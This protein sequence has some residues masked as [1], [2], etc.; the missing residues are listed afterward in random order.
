MKKIAVILLG[1]LLVSLA[2]G[3][4][5]LSY[6][7]T[8]TEIDRGAVKYAV[9]CGVADANEFKGLPNLAKAVKLESAVDD[10]HAK[11]QQEIQHMAERD[12]LEY[13]IH[14]GKAATN[15]K[16]GKEREEIL[17]GPK[18][19]IPIA[20][21]GLGFA[22]VAGYIGLMRKRPGDVT[23]EEFEEVTG[24]LLGKD[25]QI[26][27]LV[28][29]IQKYRET[30]SEEDWEDMKAIITHYQSKQTQQA[31]SNLKEIVA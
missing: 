22:S 29:S 17:F 10:G 20:L 16:V 12:T 19:I 14:S 24:D 8:L 30:L 18:G 3:C 28:K 5:P 9:D 4:L 1:I 15:V 7:V 31:V 13:S 21:S 11:R 27:E 2:V 6:Y 26:F 23:K 25:T